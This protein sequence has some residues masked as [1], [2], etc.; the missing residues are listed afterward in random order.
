MLC[1]VNIRPLPYCGA[2]I[3]DWGRG[4]IGPPGAEIGQTKALAEA[5]E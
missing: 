4:T 3:C 2:L 5:R 1:Q